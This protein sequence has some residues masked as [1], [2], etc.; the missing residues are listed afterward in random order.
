MKSEV[1]KAP[2]R[3]A[4]DDALRGMLDRAAHDV[5]ASRIVLLVKVEQV[6]RTAVSDARKRAT[7]NWPDVELV[8]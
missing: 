7:L 5:A 8:T 4:A 1:L 3:A 6:L 2:T